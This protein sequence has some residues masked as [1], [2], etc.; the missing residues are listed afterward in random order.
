MG[1]SK[2]AADAFWLF[3]KVRKIR[4]YGKLIKESINEETRP[5]GLVKLGIR[6]ML[7]IAGKALGTSLTWHPYYTYHKV[8]LEAL[9]Q[10]LNAVSNLDKARNALNSAI[11]SADASASLSKTLA[12]YQFR[13]T[14]LKLTYTMLI[15]GSLLLLREQGTSAQ[16][17]RDISSAGQTPSSLRAV[18]NASVYEWQ[19]MCCELFLESVQL[20]AMAQV[21][22]KATEAAMKQF[23]EKMKA[24]AAHGNL[25]KIASYRMQQDREWQQFD[26]MTEPNAG[27]VEAVEDPV[28]YAQNQTNMIE[29]ASDKLGQFCEAAMS[30]D[31]YNPDIILL[32]MGSF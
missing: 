20:L 10:A 7:E 16:A 30:E 24:L 1:V 27:S 32:R 25:G 17:A 6:G 19:A 15:G 13:K 22:L 23:D 14:G 21:E 8:H 28:G 31:I 3:R 18:T 2:K 4:T 26:R 12:D 29:Q 5:G 11:R 9:A